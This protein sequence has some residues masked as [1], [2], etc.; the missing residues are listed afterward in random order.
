MGETER[1]KH[2]PGFDPKKILAFFSVP[3]PLSV[4][5]TLQIQD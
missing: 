3:R 4:E 1:S 2:N 5:V